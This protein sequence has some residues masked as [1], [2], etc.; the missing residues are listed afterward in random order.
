[1]SLTENNDTTSQYN[2]TE[3]QDIYLK[4]SDKKTSNKV[5]LPN[6]GQTSG[7]SPRIVGGVKVDIKQYPWMVSFQKLSR[8]TYTHFCGGSVLNQR[9]L[10]SAAHCFHGSKHSFN[11]I[12]AMVGATNWEKGDEYVY[13]LDK[14][15]IH[16]QFSTLTYAN[17]IAL[18]K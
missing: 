16:E 3:S 9:W 15:F 13:Q 4:L 10:L 1:M 6:C 11:K 14:L 18:V 8:S 5:N 2:T 12:R 17:D 7:I